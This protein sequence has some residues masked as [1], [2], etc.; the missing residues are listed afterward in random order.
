MERGSQIICQL[1]YQH[2]FLQTQGKLA[3]PKQISSKTHFLK[4]FR[5][6]SSESNDLALRI[7]RKITGAYDVIVLDHAYHGHLTNL[8]NVSPY[9]FALPSGDGKKNWVHVAPV[10]DSYRGYCFLFSSTWLWF[11]ND[12]AKST[13]SIAAQIIVKKSWVNYTLKK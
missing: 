13:E 11:V 1:A 6:W 2:A 9:K 12:Y 3:Q 5:S 8:V 7:S 4:N 10:P